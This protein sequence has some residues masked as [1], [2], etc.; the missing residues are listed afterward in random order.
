M[1][2]GE[3]LTNVLRSGSIQSVYPLP[4][5]ERRKEIRDDVRLEIENG[6]S[7]KVKGMFTA[8]YTVLPNVMSTLYKKFEYSWLP[9]KILCL[10]G[11]KL[12]RS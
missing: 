2:V 7:G 12:L 10:S 4:S 8:F 11:T 3:G 6:D 9:S 1:G 5:I